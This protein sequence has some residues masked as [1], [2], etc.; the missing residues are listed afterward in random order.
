MNDE[1][2]EETAPTQ[3]DD[4]EDFSPKDKAPPPVKKES[5]DFKKGLQRAGLTLSFTWA[6][7]NIALG[8]LLSVGLLLNI[9]GYGYAVTDHGLVIDTLENM[10][11]DQQFQKAVI[12]S[13]KNVQ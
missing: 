13:M 6:Y 7:V 5:S 9:L 8:A 2:S 3:D 11:R 12:E 10:R 4:L 1:D